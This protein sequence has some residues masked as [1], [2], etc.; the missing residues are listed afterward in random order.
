MFEKRG[1]WERELQATGIDAHGARHELPLRRI[2]GYA[3]G[4]T[5]LYAYQQ[6][7]TLNETN[8]TGG[9]AAFAAY[10]A[11]RAAELGVHVSAIELRWIATSLEDG[12]VEEH[13]I[14]TFSVGANP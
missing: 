9:Q 5:P 12:H 13:P 2:F 8:A 1:P 6:L 11:R 7:E 14:G 10:V 3:R 4:A